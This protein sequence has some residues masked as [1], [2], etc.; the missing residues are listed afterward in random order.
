MS[1]RGRQGF[2]V[3]ALPVQREREGLQRPGQAGGVA[4]AVEPVGRPP[5][6]GHGLRVRPVVHEQVTEVP[7]AGGEDA[8]AAGGG[9]DLHGPPVGAL[10]LRP[11]AG[12]LPD[13]AE[14]DE[15]LARLG[16]RQE[17]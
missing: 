1:L 10:G 12:Q 9:G 3:G 5:Q 17:R 13:T 15:H 6:P 7:L 16:L 14:L 8:R 11:L 4:E 2:G